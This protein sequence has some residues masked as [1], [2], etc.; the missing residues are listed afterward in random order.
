M[1]GFFD[2]G[3]NQCV[4]SLAGHGSSAQENWLG[5]ALIHRYCHLE[6]QRELNQAPVNMDEKER[7]VVFVADPQR[8]RLS[9]FAC[10]HLLEISRYFGGSL[11]VLLIWREVVQFVYL[12]KCL[13]WVSWKK[14]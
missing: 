7:T 5:T 4:G 8:L 3:R 10:E 9:R 6:N 1:G 14:E 2:T 11:P 13:E 12:G